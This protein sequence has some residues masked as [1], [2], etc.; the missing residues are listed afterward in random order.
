[1]DKFLFLKS[2]RFWALVIGGLTVV[3]EGNFTLDAWLKGVGIVV[4][5]FIGIRTLDRS[6]EFLGG[7]RKDV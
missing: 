6:A 1:M 2:T 4:V 3:A 5:G 7:A